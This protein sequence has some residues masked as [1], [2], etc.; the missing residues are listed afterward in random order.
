MT[1]GSDRL[2]GKVA[3][4]TGGGRG[5]G[6]SMVLGLVQAGATVVTT[7]AREKAEVE[8]VASE[9]KEMGYAGRILPLLADVTRAEVCTRTV[10][11][12]LS[13]FGRLDI[14]VNNAGRGMKYVSEAFLT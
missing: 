14:L 11:T 9:A 2:A 3:V 6:R 4:V 8:Q 1:T 12:A 7:A 5:L 10:E 13:H